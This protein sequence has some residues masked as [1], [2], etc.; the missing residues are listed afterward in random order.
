MWLVSRFRDKL[1]ELS[2][3]AGATF[4][5]TLP[6]PHAPPIRSSSSILDLSSTLPP[7][8]SVGLL[9]LVPSCTPFFTALCLPTILP[10]SMLLSIK[11]FPT[12]FFVPADSCHPQWHASLLVPSFRQSRRS[13]LL[14]SGPQ[15][16][17]SVCSQSLF[18]FSSFHCISWCRLYHIYWFCSRFYRHLC[19]SLHS[20]RWWSYLCRCCSQISHPNQP[21]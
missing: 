7:S 16:R 11:I 9:V 18:H 21:L 6:S 2:I 5:L 17:W 20:D 8:N 15:F 13:H 14:A 3:H 12:V 19:H 1:S 4:C 10:G